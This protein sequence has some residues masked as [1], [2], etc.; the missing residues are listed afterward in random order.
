MAQNSVSSNGE[1]GKRNM[2][3]KEY[4]IVE[5]PSGIGNGTY[6]AC[7][8]CGAGLNVWAD[9]QTVRDEMAGEIEEKVINPLGLLAGLLANVKEDDYEVDISATGYL[10][11]LFVHGARKE[12]EIQK[13]GGSGAYWIMQLIEGH[14]K[15]KE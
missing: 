14:D 9:R 5:A 1:N 11:G 12:L 6:Y 13:V 7:G 8:K 15:E 4:D 10:L 2:H 3:S